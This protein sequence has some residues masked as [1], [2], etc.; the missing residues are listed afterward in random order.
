MV[1][2]SAGLPIITTYF[3]G[4]RSRLGAN[5]MAVGSEIFCPSRFRLHFSLKFKSMG[6]TEAKVAYVTEKSN[7]P[8]EIFGALL[9]VVVGSVRIVQP[10]LII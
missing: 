7:N 2:I 5:W 10:T 8:T 3:V 9:S 1:Q 6:L 4:F